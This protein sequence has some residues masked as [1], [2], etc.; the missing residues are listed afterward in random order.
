MFDAK[1]INNP[2]SDETFQE[3]HANHR[4]ADAV[5]VEGMSSHKMLMLLLSFNWEIWPCLQRQPPINTRNKQAVQLS[6][7]HWLLA[8][9][10]FQIWVHTNVKRMRRITSGRPGLVNDLNT[11]LKFDRGTQLHNGS[12]FGISLIIIEY[13]L[14]AQ[15]GLTSGSLSH[16][17]VWIGWTVKRYI[18]CRDVNNVDIPFWKLWR[19]QPTYHCAGGDRATRGKAKDREGELREGEECPY[20]HCIEPGQPGWSSRDNRRWWEVPMPAVFEGEEMTFRSPNR[21]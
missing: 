16:S 14:K 15:Q 8:V 10:L 5:D 7:N 1:P 17:T 6:L 19:Y 12:G 3:Y 11:T 2:H 20:G 4:C 21:Y 18:F 13:V 9:Q